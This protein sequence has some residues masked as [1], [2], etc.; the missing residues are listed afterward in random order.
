MSAYL[1]QEYDFIERTKTIIEQYASIKDSKKY[2]VTLLMNCFIGLLIL[3][4]QHWYDK[5]PDIIISE[6]EWGISADDISFIKISEKKDIKN[7]SRH[8]RNSI[9]HYRFTAFKDDSNNISQIRFED[10]NKHDGKTFEATLSVSS[11]KKF[12]FHFSELLCEIMKKEKSEL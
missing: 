12:I 4:Q 2:E 11:I 10:N 3:P 9:S 8:L 6:K 7:I 5:L 1:Q